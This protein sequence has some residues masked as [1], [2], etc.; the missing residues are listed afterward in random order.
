MA[1]TVSLIV[2]IPISI[3]MV[4]VFERRRW[5]SFGIQFDGRMLSEHLKGLSLSSVMMI[6]IVLS[7]I[8]GSVL[9]FESKHL[10]FTEYFFRL[11]LG[12]TFF[13]VAALVEEL[14]FRGYLFQT[15]IEIMNP[16]WATII[17]SLFFGAAHFMNPHAT[18]FSS[19]NIVLAGIFLSIC[20]LKTKSLWFCTAVHFGWNYCQGVIFSLPVSGLH[21][22]A[23]AL[24]TVHIDQAEWLTGGSFGP[25]GGAA[26][27]VILIVAIAF[28]LKTNYIKE[29]KN[30]ISE[31]CVNHFESINE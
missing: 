2:L 21:P 7:F 4:T 15:L 8:A 30:S 20:Y 17:F 19:C 23:Y 13:Y 29:Y 18:F 12:A 27:F 28:L 3:L 6:A 22:D 1:S 11:I 24:F 9:T 25:E 14:L 16:I 5:D 31:V 26:A 10:T